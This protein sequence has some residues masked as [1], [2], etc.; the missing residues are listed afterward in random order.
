[1]LVV[2]V[3]LMQSQCALVITCMNGSLVVLV[4]HVAYVQTQMYF[5]CTYRSLGELTVKG[6]ACGSLCE[7]L[8]TCK[9]LHEHVVTWYTCGSLGML[10]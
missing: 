8:V 9:T 6:C 5:S 4:G 7:I 10:V 2:H 1:M 3:V